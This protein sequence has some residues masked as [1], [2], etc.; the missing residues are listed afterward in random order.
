MK[1]T[2]LILLI[3]LSGW[4]PMACTTPFAK[5]TK[6]TQEQTEKTK[7]PRMVSAMAYEHY[8]R[9]KLFFE[10]AKIREATQEMRQALLYDHASPMLHVTLG[11]L[12]ARQGLWRLAVKESKQALVLAPQSVPALMLKAA[13]LGW[14]NQYAKAIEVYRNIIQLDPK[15]IT[16]Y[17]QIAKIHIEKGEKK[18][19]TQALEEMV[20]A[21]PESAEGF[22]HLGQLAFEQGD[23]KKAEQYFRRCLQIDPS[24]PR[25]THTLTG[26]LEQQGRY[27]EAIQVFIEALESRPED[28]YYMAYMARLYLKD[29]D[30]DAAN[31]YIEQMRASGPANA[32]LIARAYAE[33][34]RHEEAIAE[35]EKV[36]QSHP[37]E[38]NERLL[39]AV[40]YEELKQWDRAL[41]HLAKIPPSAGYYI[42]AQ[43]SIGYCLHHKGQYKKAIKVLK[44]TLRLAQEP[45]AI[46]R[47]Y[48]HL[49]ATYSKVKQYGKGLQLLDQALVKFPEMNDL[50]EAKANLLFEATRAEEGVLVL[51][52][53]LAREPDNISLLYALGSLYER[54]GQGPKSIQTMRKILAIDPNNSAALNFIG[55]T[56]ADQGQDLEEAERLVRRALMLNPGNGAITD[57]L[58]WILYKRGDYKNALE[59]L[60]RADR[61]TPGEAVI[62]MHV[63]DAYLR[64][65]NHDKAI[66]YYR[67]AW[68]SGPEERDK[69]ELRQR[70]EKLGLK[71]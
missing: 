51:K 13:G 28:P 53:A 34:N 62:I 36:L 47:I 42:N 45:D 54:M 63:G 5:Q 40:L 1:P 65:G 25:T 66:E 17:S 61:I 26:L 52:K 6:P 23:E 39:L 68:A 67:R 60:I 4:A 9:A 56:L 50:L 16:A 14:A 20:T 19:A 32:G 10:Q 24:D 41:S 21:N 15:N 31:A 30:N 57:S 27:K 37:H 64:L 55:Y 46:G 70:F 48:R 3:S 12:Y 7:K 2:H 69:N 43:T 58:G 59:Y 18:Q 11:G 35:L 71:P 33:I 29:G 38:H 44:D 8:L 22:R 49:A